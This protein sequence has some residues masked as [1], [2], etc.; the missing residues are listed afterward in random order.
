MLV[1]L[2]AFQWIAVAVFAFSVH[3]NGWLFYQGG[4]QIWYWTTSWLSGHGWIPK[5]L[6]SPAW[7][8][9][10]VP[11]ALIAGKVWAT[12]P[13][14]STCSDGRRHYRISR[15]RH[16]SRATAMSRIALGLTEVGCW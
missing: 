11:F 12:A 2:L 1:P 15:N 16:R 14:S 7:T 6:I 4:D 3:H 9:V 13:A 8:F 5:T 10:L